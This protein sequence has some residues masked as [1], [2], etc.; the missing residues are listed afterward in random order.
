MLQKCEKVPYIFKKYE[1]ICL[2]LFTIW[3]S[4]LK[5]P[6][7]LIQKISSHS[8]A[9]KGK[10]KSVLVLQWQKINK[11]RSKYVIKASAFYKIQN[12]FCFF[13][14]KPSFGTWEKCICGC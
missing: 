1:K 3:N 5:Q 2:K 10:Q 8:D 6:I 4:I 9:Q 14:S 11:N 7:N 13:L 12:F